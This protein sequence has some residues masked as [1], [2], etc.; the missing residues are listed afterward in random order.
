MKNQKATHNKKRSFVWALTI[1]M[2][3]GL[4]ASVASA[5]TT[6]YVKATAD[7]GGDGSKKRPFNSLQAVE[8]ISEPGD[9][10][11]ILHCPA[12]TPALNGGIALKDGQK[13]I[14][15]GP[16]VTKAAPQ[17][18]RAKITNSNDERNWGDAIWLAND[19]EVTNIH[20]IDAYSTA[21]LGLD[22]IGA[23]IHHNLIT[24]HN[25]GCSY[26][27]LP[28]G[29][30]LALF[31]IVFYSWSAMMGDLLVHH[32]VV[33]DA[34]GGGVVL[35]LFGS[36]SA[37]LQLDE[38]SFTDLSPPSI[39]GDGGR[40]EAIAIST[41]NTRANVIIRDTF[42]DNIGHTGN[43]N[44]DSIVSVM[45]GSSQQDVL[46]QNYTYRN[47]EDVGGSSATGI[48]FWITPWAANATLDF[49]LE[50]SDLRGMNGWCGVQLYVQGKDCELT[51]EVENTVVENST[52]DGIGIYNAGPGPGN[53]YE[54][55]LE[56]NQVIDCPGDGISFY[57]Y[58]GSIENVNISLEDNTVIDCLWRGFAFRNDSSIENVEISLKDN[59]F[60]G[61][62]IGGC[63]LRTSAYDEEGKHWG[64]PIGY[65]GVM[66][67]G[68]D[69]VGGE[70]GVDFHDEDGLTDSSIIDLGGGLVLGSAGYNRIFDNTNA[71]V[72]WNYDVVAK[73]NWWGSP[74]GPSSFLLEGSATF[75]FE[76]FLTEDPRP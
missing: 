6:W 59:A 73:N 16:D 44:S 66:M 50:D 39:L 10:I 64:G 13:L 33:R 23:N 18:A 56:G 8:E 36:A 15:T 57:N 14:G 75:D 34:E 71:V 9:T 48:E 49:R 54:I 76:P 43:S 12:D 38:N 46:I 19:N 69:L 37:E 32:N 55:H 58:S 28:S 24:G 22:I 20:I 2:S 35:Y 7:D 21:I 26:I 31:G 47:T 42:V 11:I 52:E 67:E 5:E 4:L 63:Y 61:N 17:S 41:D 29:Q 72:I 1:L 30:E 25:Q 53:N 27:W 68:N 70:Y 60:L 74:T 51:W 45:Y 65:L 3:I 40:V 62:S